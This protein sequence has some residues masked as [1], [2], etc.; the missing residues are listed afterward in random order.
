MMSGFPGSARTWAKFRR[1]AWS[2]TYETRRDEK[3][4]HGPACI[5]FILQAHSQA[6]GIHVS[7]RAVAHEH[8]DLALV[9]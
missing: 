7:F 5:A 9:T 8:Y 3:V 1:S 2:D 6:S 4:P